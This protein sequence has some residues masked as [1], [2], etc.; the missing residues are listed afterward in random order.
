[1]L[2]TGVK[3]LAVTG[4]VAGSV[5]AAA[6]PVVAETDPSPARPAT[7]VPPVTWKD[8]RT[9]EGILSPPAGPVGV[10]PGGT[11][12]TG[13]ESKDAA[14]LAATYFQCALGGRVTG[15]T[16]WAT[17]QGAIQHGTTIGCWAP[18][19][20]VP[21]TY[22]RTRLYKYVNNAWNLV[23]E[24]SNQYPSVNLSVQKN[25]PCGSHSQ[26]SGYQY[27]W[28]A[29]HGWE[30]GPGYTPIYD[31]THCTSNGVYTTCDY[32]NIFSY[33]SGYDYVLNTQ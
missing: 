5:G 4:M 29:T 14:A 3:A 18:P 23:S 33:T 28:V 15:F 31:P 7:T 25:F 30:A 12:K 1:M 6:L 32:A 11:A 10:A 27:K 21:L 13:K 22:V 9:M 24:N 8:T 16:N 20:A 2:R 26:C 17:Q 19:T